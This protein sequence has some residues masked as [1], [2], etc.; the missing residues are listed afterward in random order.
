MAKPL[1]MVIEDHE[2][3][4]DIYMAA[5]EMEGFETVGITDGKEALEELGNMTPALIILDMNLPHISGH[6]L[7]KHIRGDDRLKE[8][9]VII[10]TANSILAGNV[11]IDK[12]EHDFVLM[13]PIEIRQLQD[14]VRK[15]KKQFSS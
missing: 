4:R 15:L 7:L 13:K 8:V 6:Y 2:S 1:A 3:I 12:T 9:P 14:L 10:S 5:L 11:A